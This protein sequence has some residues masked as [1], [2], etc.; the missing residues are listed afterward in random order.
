MSVEGRVGLAKMLKIL[1]PLAGDGAKAHVSTHTC[2]N[3][4]HSA[5]AKYYFAE[6]LYVT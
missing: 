4:L 1:T 6:I 5:P 2:P 3:F